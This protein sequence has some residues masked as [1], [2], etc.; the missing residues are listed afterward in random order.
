MPKVTS[1]RVIITILEESSSTHSP[2]EWF[3]AS[4]EPVDI[5]LLSLTP[6]EE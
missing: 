1:A 5:Q 2:D 3:I 6:N 4:L